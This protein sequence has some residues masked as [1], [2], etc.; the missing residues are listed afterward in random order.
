MNGPDFLNKK[1]EYSVTFALF[2]RKS[3]CPMSSAGFEGYLSCS[4]VIHT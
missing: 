2:A 4:Q 3:T 1:I